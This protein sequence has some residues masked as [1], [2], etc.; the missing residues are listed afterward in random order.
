MEKFGISADSLPRVVA[1]VGENGGSRD[2]DKVL[3]YEGATDFERLSDFIRDTSSGGLALVDLR[4]E[5]AHCKREIKGLKMELEQEREA[6]KSARAEVVRS[7]LGQ[8]GQVEAVKRGLETELHEARQKE[9]AAQDTIRAET[10]RMGAL[11]SGLEYE[12]NGLASQVKAYEDV[13]GERV[14]MLQQSNMDVFLSSTARPLKAVLFTT[15][16]ETPPLWSQLAEAQSMTTAFGVIKHVEQELMER[17]QLDSEDLPRICIWSSEK[18]EPVVYDGEVKLDALSSFLKDAVH[19]GDTV[20]A[21]RQQVHSAVRHV[22]DMVAELKR[23]NLEAL[24]KQEESQRRCTEMEEAHEFEVGQLKAQ[25]R[26]LTEASSADLNRVSQSARTSLNDAKDRI[27]TLEKELLSERASLRKELEQVRAQAASDMACER[28]AV[29][30]ER[31]SWADNRDGE[32]ILREEIESMERLAR[33]ADRAVGRAASAVQITLV[34]KDREMERMQ[35]S[36]R[37]FIDDVAPVQLQAA[38]YDAATVRAT[39]RSHNGLADGG[40]GIM[41]AVGAI[42]QQ[43]RSFKDKING[44]DLLGD[45]MG[46]DPGPLANVSFSL[47]TPRPESLNS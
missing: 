3:P 12:R 35:R 45:K 6:V 30:R 34:R 18:E 8:V 41:G 10:E 19:G 4:Q 47:P 1:V 43:Y 21:M 9:K 2:K 25:L 36:L 14:L 13:Q 22:E 39:L 40:E 38:V 26:K 17:F 44:L 37:E 5:M 20:I 31:D 27:L 24:A 29:E 23:V 16:A 15:K 42:S 7:K 11:I 28:Q 46:L 33:H 32:R